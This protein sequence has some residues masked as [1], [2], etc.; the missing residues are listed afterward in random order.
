MNKEKLISDFNNL[1]Y[2]EHI[3][4]K[5]KWFGYNILKC[6]TDLFVYQ[7]I[8][9]EVKPDII[10]EGGTSEGGSTLYLAHLC[11]LIGNGEVFSVDI[12]ADDHNIR[13]AHPRI[14]YILGSMLDKNIVN[15]LSN[16]A[17]DKKVL[18][19]LDDDHN[20]DHVLKELHT[21]HSLVKSGSYIIVEDGLET[22]KTHKLA[23]GPA[24]AVKSFL[25]ENKNFKVDQS[26]E[27]FLLTFNTSGYLKRV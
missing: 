2:N 20:A 24:A 22:R 19:I 21:Y 1:Y 23:G 27:K 3:W 9:N 16:K 15:Y 4:R 13:P 26:K 18:I 7:E 10:I 8:I 5:T 11:D 12:L 17:K 14:E 6:P 25:K